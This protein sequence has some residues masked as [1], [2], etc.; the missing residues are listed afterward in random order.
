MLREQRVFPHGG[1][2]LQLPGW[3]IL[4]SFKIAG[5]TIFRGISAHDA[6]KPNTVNSEISYAI[7]S[8][9]E[10]RKFSLESKHSNKAVI[11][12]NRPLDFDG[13]D[14]FFNLTIRAQV[15]NAP[16]YAGD[17]V[18]PREGGTFGTCL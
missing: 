1:M 17:F 10:A 18:K 6:D 7:L 12:L 15:R 8:G 16:G 2:S 14:R 11:N 5:L 4:I 13:G 9:N 3:S